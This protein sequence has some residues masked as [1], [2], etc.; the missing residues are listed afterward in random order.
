MNK[1]MS[2]KVSW[3]S[4]GRA[5]ESRRFDEWEPAVEFY[6]GLAADRRTDAAKL[7]EVTEAEVRCFEREAAAARREPASAVAAGGRM[8]SPPAVPA[9]PGRTWL[10]G[11]EDAP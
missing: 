5:E 1:R 3:T 9:G 11:T 8:M 4:G 7:V 2:Y 6:R 10:T